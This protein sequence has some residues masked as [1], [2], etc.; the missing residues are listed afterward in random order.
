MLEGNLKREINVAIGK[1]NELYHKRP[2]I[3][4]GKLDLK[5]LNYKYVDSIVRENKDLDGLVG[6]FVGFNIE[7]G[8]FEFGF[9]LK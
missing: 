2:T 5:E 6:N 3:I 9:I 1:Y 4:V 8:D 7:E